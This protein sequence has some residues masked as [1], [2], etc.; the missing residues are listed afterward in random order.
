MKNIMK[1][2]KVGK[3]LFTA[4]ASVIALFILAIVVAVTCITIINN[5]MNVFY[6]Q[7]YQNS[8]LQLEIRKDVQYVGK[9]LLWATTTDSK[10]GTKEHLQEA[11]NYMPKITN[12]IELLKQ[13]FEHQELL[14]ELD[15]VISDLKKAT[16]QVSD[17]AA[18]NFN[19]EALE[20]YN[21][22]YNN[23]TLKLQN[24]LTE[25]GNYT[26][27]A[28]KRDYSGARKLGIASTI[29]M[30][31]VG[32]VSILICLYFSA[33][34]TAV[35]KNPILELER[36]ADKLKK[37]ELDA[38]I[39]YESK[40]EMGSLADSFREACTFMGDVIGDT[41]ELLGQMAEGNFCV[42]TKIEEKYVGEFVHLKNAM[43]KLNK[44]LSSTLNQINEASDQVAIGA[45][46]MADSAQ[47]LAEGATEQAGTVEE[48]TAT[49]ENVAVLSD[50]NAQNAEKAYK[51]MK[52]AETEAEKGQQDMNELISAMERISNTS[53][54]IQNIIASIED[55]ASQTNLL[56]L[57]AS[58]EAARAGE[59]GRGFAVV[60]DQIGKLASDSAQSAVNT[61]EL[62]VKA[63]EEVENGNEITQKTVNILEKIIRNMS[64]FAETS[65]DATDSSKAQ[66][67]M[68]NQLKEGIEQ[69]SG[70]IQSN[71]AA[72]QETS[73]SS[74]ELSAQSDSLK[75]LV[76]KFQLRN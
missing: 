28:A 21:N 54:E 66:A 20:I 38:E 51:Q 72:A 42:S 70:V 57:N 6:T 65:R 63:L 52:E 33:L 14:A 26:D 9:Q 12:N 3:K 59:A 40:D 11:E 44:D 69:I 32:I 35:I 24:I 10:E 46:Q 71:S 47:S 45:S 36:A 18:E 4:F 39:T 23:T 75:E 30:I 27:Q 17:F 43:H 1:N 13:N 73:A 58:I 29:I 15:S 22:E 7:S 2:M 76:G 34:I 67:E 5:N 37:G 68:L 55:I 61:R 62:I 56:S 74:E 31:V 16:T 8:N 60:A 19:E 64:E 41:G 53:K 48:L 50:E 25:I 49:M